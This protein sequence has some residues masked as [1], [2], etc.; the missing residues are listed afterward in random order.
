MAWRFHVVD[1]ADQNKFFLLPEQGKVTLGRS[2]RHADIILHDLYVARVHCEVEVEEND[3]LVRLFPEATAG[4]LINGVKSGEH[5]LHPGDILRIGNSHLK[6]EPHE[7]G[8]DPEEDEEEAIEAEVVEDD[9]PRPLPIVPYERLAELVSH[10]LSHY[11]IV[12]LLGQGHYGFVFKAK[13]AKGAEVALKVLSPEFPADP[14]EMKVFVAALKDLLLLR[15]PNLVSLLNAGKTGPYCWMA[16]EH[17][18]GDSLGH[19]LKEP[20][21]KRRSHW[22][23]ALKMGIQ[24]AQALD[25]LRKHKVVHGNISPANVLMGRDKVGRDTAVKLGDLMLSRALD[26]SA[27]QEARLEKKL[28]AEV[29]YL[30]PEQTYADGRIDRLTDL[31]GLGAVLYAR[32]TGGP[33]FQGRNAEDTIE[34]IN[35]SYPRK[36]IDIHKNIPEELST[37]VMLLLSRRPEDRYQS[38]RELL[39]ALEDIAEYEGVETS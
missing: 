9:E 2:Q 14:Q 16:L 11:Q 27:L 12:D 26:G 5:R 30:A 25:F 19:A 38:P 23:P 13:H 39:E 10:T 24:L 36:P 6:L 1:G 28:A 8:T 22:K 17:V 34:L 20:D 15:H 7:A 18:E 29:G 4:M 3:V 32:L 21:A 33:P 31:Y 37:A 35:T